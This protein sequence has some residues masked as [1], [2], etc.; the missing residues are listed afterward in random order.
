MII[1]YLSDGDLNSEAHSLL[2]PWRIGRLREEGIYLTDVDLNSEAH[3][4]LP[5]WRIGILCAEGKP[6]K[7]ADCYNYATSSPTAA[8]NNRNQS[9]LSS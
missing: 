5:P 3:S 2:P 6:F 1:I 4:L 9:S 7:I 8:S